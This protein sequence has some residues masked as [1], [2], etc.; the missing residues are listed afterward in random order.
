MPATSPFDQYEVGTI[1]RIHTRDPRWPHV[2]LRE[3]EGSRDLFDG[4]DR[5][6]PSYDWE[7][8]IPVVAPSKYR[9]VDVVESTKYPFDSV[10]EIDR[11][12]GVEYFVR[13]D[14]VRKSAWPGEPV[15]IEPEN[16]EPEESKPVVY[17]PAGRVAK[18]LRDAAYSITNV[19]D[20]YGDN[21]AEMQARSVVAEA[22]GDL[23]SSFESYDPEED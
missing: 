12:G 4:M 3:V 22:L 11:G 6:V 21:D 2:T 7:R 8:A 1:F 15:T 17:V 13:R 14:A 9:A 19:Y 18:M 10:R 20:H 16:A 23:A 5:H